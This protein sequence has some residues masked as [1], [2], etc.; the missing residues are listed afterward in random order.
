M[1]REGP[2][3]LSCSLGLPFCSLKV[4][5]SVLWALRVCASDCVCLWASL[6]IWGADARGVCVGVCVCVWCEWARAP[7][8]AP[9]TSSQGRALA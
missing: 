8:L 5:V 4:S 6:C 3:A 7:P 1:L 9:S 2:L